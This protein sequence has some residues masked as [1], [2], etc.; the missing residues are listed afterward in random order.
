MLG[1]QVTLQSL[2]EES[3]H[4]FKWEILR[5]QLLKLQVFA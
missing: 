2:N 4:H 5:Q 1:T 3:P